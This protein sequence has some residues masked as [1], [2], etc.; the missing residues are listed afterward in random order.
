[1]PRRIRLGAPRDAGAAALP[2]TAAADDVVRVE[3]ENGLALWM[4]AD[5]LLKERGERVVGRDAAGA[6][7]IVDPSPRPGLRQRSAADRGSERGV[8]GIGIK[9]LE[10]F[11]VDLKKKSAA[12]LSRT[13]EERQLK[14]HAPGLYRV[15][16]DAGGAQV[17]VDA[18]APPLPADRPILLFL[19]GTMSSVMGSFG[20]LWSTTGEDGGRAALQAREAL[21]ARY[22]AD[23]Y[24]FEHRTLTESPIQNALELVG[25]LPDGA[26]LDLVSHSRGGLVG[27]LLCLADRDR[28][29]DPLGEAALG[30]LF[31]ADRTV[32]T[33]LGLGALDGAAAAARDKAY[34]DDRARL[35]KL[36]KLLD[37]KRIKVRRFVRVAC[38]AR[39]TT[40]TSGR[41]DRWLSV[42]N[43][44]T[45]NGLIADAADFLLAVVK[46]RTDPRTLPGLEAMMPGSAL[47]RLLQHP[48]LVTSADLSV[49]AGDVEGQGVW[50][51]LK[52]LAVDW[53][54]G[55]DH[56][57]VVNT[58][59]MFGGIRR[60]AGGARFLRDQG[61][62]VTHF[63]YFAN[64]EVGRLARQ[65]P[66]ARGRP[67]RR[68][69]AA[70]R[71]QDRRSRAGA[72]RCGRAAPRHAAPARD[73]RAGHDGQRARGARQAGLAR[74]TGRCC[75]AASPTSAGARPTSRSATSSTTST[76]RCSST[77]RARTAS[78]SSRTTG[79][80]RSSMRRAHWPSVSRRCCPKPSGP[81][82][83]S[84]SSPIRWADWLRAR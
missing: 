63:N 10:I 66:A 65:R 77:S 41:L 25:Q 27:E 60:P 44:L 51:Q 38:P 61:E 76:A 75:A 54:Y 73:R 24:A 50:A 71:S 34:A 35:A 81:G 68:L 42:I 7:W 62:R 57:L 45:G 55:S 31:A 2:V 9:V 6:E 5:D 46:E 21:R 59:S 18:T 83:R 82:S 3:Y 40:L 4:R 64:A 26:Q 67:E 33:Q 32:A 74:R 16:F 12:L 17:A 48:A 53:F 79:A 43:L 30:A 80:A 28:R 37:A 1:M 70:R 23:V 84:T 13:F 36:V 49:I 78:R 8:V 56:D 29:D 47:T 52:L 19:H 11:G 14:G 72:R 39:G 58:G 69:H 15:P 20:D 22:G